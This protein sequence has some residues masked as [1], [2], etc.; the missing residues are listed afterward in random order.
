MLV[1]LF[2]DTTPPVI[3][4]PE[5][6]TVIGQPGETYVYLNYDWEPV[7]VSSLF[8]RIFIGHNV[9]CYINTA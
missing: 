3:S 2:K 5:V 6:V 1:R 4:G 7:T 9:T 8:Y